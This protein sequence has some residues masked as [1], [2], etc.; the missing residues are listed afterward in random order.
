[1]AIICLMMS[2]IKTWCWPSSHWQT[3]KVETFQWIN[4]ESWSEAKAPTTQVKQEDKLEKSS[5]A[6]ICPNKELSQTHRWPLNWII[7]LTDFK[8]WAETNDKKLLFEFILNLQSSFEI[9]K[10][11]LDLKFFYSIWKFIS[12]MDPTEWCHVCD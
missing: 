3:R 7:L 8:T 4:H 10:F 2:W 1:M 9:W 5:V 6:I 11:D 12:N